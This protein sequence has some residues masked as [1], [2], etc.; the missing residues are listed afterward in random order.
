MKKCLHTSVSEDDYEWFKVLSAKDELPV[1]A[2][3]RRA[4]KDY[5]KRIEDADSNGDIP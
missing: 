4:A 1:A 5:R 2:H 3:L